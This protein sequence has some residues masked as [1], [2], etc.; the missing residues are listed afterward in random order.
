MVITSIVVDLER[1]GE[2]CA[3][4]VERVLGVLLDIVEEEALD[5][6]LMQNDLLEARESNGNIG[7]AIRASNNAV[8]ARV[9][10]T[11]RIVLIQRV[12][13]HTHKQI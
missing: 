9:L 2:D 3:F 7:D 10:N 4:D 12:L 1:F 8:F 13:L 11:S 6:P 5:T